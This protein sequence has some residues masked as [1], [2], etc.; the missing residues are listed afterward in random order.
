[1]SNFNTASQVAASVATGSCG[2]WGGLCLKMAPPYLTVDQNQTYTG[3][4]WQLLGNVWECPR[5]LGFWA[6]HDKTQPPSATFC[7]LRL[8][9]AHS[10]HFCASLAILM[11]LCR[12]SR[13]VSRKAK[14]LGQSEM[15]LV[16]FWGGFM[17][18]WCQFVNTEIREQW[19]LWLWMSWWGNVH[20]KVQKEKFG[21]FGNTEPINW[22]IIAASAKP[23]RTNASAKL[24][25][26]GCQGTV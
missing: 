23:W 14:A 4:H 11:R 16:N 21:P 17:A 26:Q 9:T 3:N 24:T 15:P 5:F 19:C 22:N 13:T 1:M 20:D 25:C 6:N 8:S 18:R 2:L 12:R 10:V 7:N